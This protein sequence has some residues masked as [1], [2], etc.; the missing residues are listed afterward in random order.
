QNYLSG[1][2]E[3]SRSLYVGDVLGYDADGLAEVAVK[4]HF[5]VGDRIEI[6]R[7]AG[8]FELV[9]EA[10]QNREGEAVTVAPGSGHLMRIALPPDCEGA[11]VAKYL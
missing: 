5:A 2:S 4:N 8:N 10:M 9:I 11:F 7:P 3:S 1:S 6:I